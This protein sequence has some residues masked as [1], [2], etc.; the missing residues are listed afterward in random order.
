MCPYLHVSTLDVWQLNIRIAA[1]KDQCPWTTRATRRGSWDQRVP[2]QTRDE[3]ERVLPLA[4][5]EEADRRVGRADEAAER[6]AH[7]DAHEGVEEDPEAQEPAMSR[8]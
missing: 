5:A 8:A 1:G 6:P 4:A 7:L 3:D 2:D